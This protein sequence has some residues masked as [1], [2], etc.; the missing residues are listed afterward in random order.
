[1]NGTTR[2]PGG[3]HLDAETLD[4]YRRRVAPPAELLEADA[5]LASCDLCHDTVRADVDTIDLPPARDAHLT[6]EELEAFVD[7]RADALDRELIA[8]HVELC[9]LCRGELADLSSARDAMGLR[10]TLAPAR[11]VRVGRGRDAADP[12]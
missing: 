2:Q 8:A 11:R 10:S 3:L 12:R 5:H 4:R 1:M 9:P 7:A 6:Y